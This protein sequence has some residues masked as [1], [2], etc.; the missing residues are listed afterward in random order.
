MENT[1]SKP[2]PNYHRW[3]VSQVCRSEGYKEYRC[4]PAHWL[5]H[6]EWPM[7]FPAAESLSTLM[8]LDKDPDFW[9]ASDAALR[10]RE[11]R[12]GNLGFRELQIYATRRS[13]DYNRPQPWAARAIAIALEQ[14]WSGGNDP[15]VHPFANIDKENEEGLWG[16]YGLQLQSEHLTNRYEYQVVTGMGIRPSKRSRPPHRPWYGGIGSWFSWRSL[17]DWKTVLRRQDIEHEL[18]ASP[19][20]GSLLLFVSHRWED[21]SHPD[22]TGRQLLALKVGL[23]MSLAA[24]ICSKNSTASTSSGLPEVFHEFLRETSF[25]KGG[26][27]RLDAWANEVREAATTTSSEEDFLTEMSRLERSCG[28][29]SDLSRLRD[30]VLIWYDYASMFQKPRSES[31]EVTFR[32]ELEL[33]NDIQA[34]AVTVVLGEEEY[35][36]RVWCFLELCGGIRNSIVELSP[37]WTKSLRLSSSINSWAH[38]SDQLIGALNYFGEEAIATS[39]LSATEESDL[40]IVG[41]LIKRLPLF[42]LVETD[43]MDLVGGSIPFAFQQGEGWITSGGHQ[44]PSTVTLLNPVENHGEVCERTILHEAA[45]GASQA[46]YFQG[47]CG[48]WVYT[49]Q[50][51]LSLS[52]AAKAAEF[53]RLIDGEAEIGPLGGVAC[54]W[55]DSR[56]LAEDGFGWTRVIPSEMKTLVIVTQVDIPDICLLYSQVIGSHLTAGRRVIV[57]HPETGE[58]KFF[59]RQRSDRGRGA[60]RN[61]LVVPRIRRATAYVQYLLTGEMEQSTLEAMSALRIEPSIE[62]LLSIELDKDKLAQLSEMRVRAEC[63]ARTKLACWEALAEHGLDPLSWKSVDL[64][65]EQLRIA[66]KVIGIVAEFGDNPLMRRQLL[67]KILEHETEEGKPLDQDF[68][69]RVGEIIKFVSEQSS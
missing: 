34:S 26:E 12:A 31:E 44:A 61:A 35:L 32:E 39:G 22:P 25:L 20:P 14:E 6:G 54:T 58:L 11:I 50:R 23:T 43:G 47:E 36:S 67:Y 13:N 66:R 19:R 62:N 38:I 24:A 5:P 3:E 40:P 28:V 49:T 2:D 59:D 10:A 4:I 42:G 45:I 65:E 29:T 41:R 33:L 69:P 63:E 37:T 18:I 30:H 21:Y 64:A 57:F 27:S 16:H 15:H 56:C 7:I 48:I 46:E 1:S 60:M 51:I 53:Y 9:S 52:W 8:G 68:V 17:Q 55:A